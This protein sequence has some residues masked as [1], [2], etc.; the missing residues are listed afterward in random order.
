[1]TASGEQAPA[2]EQVAA[3]GNDVELIGHSYRA[4]IDG[5]AFDALIEAWNRRI[6]SVGH[7]DGALRFDSALLDQLAEVDKLA[8]GKLQIV[9][10]DPVDELLARCVTAA[11]VQNADGRVVAINPKGRESFALET[12]DIDRGAWLAPAQISTLRQLRSQAHERGNADRRVVEC[13]DPAEADADHKMQ[14][15]EARLVT[16]PGY[17]QSLVLV[18]SLEFLWLET[19]SDLVEQS[20]GLTEAE[21]EIAR[22]FYRHRSLQ[23]IAEMRG[24]SVQTI[25]TQFKAVLAKS[26]CRGQVEL[27]RVLTALC[28]QS[29]IDAEPYEGEWVNPYRNEQ[30]IVRPGGKMLGYS[31]AGPK[32]GRPLLW[33]HGP[34]FNYALPRAVLDALDDLR[35]RLIIPCR[36]GYGGSE[37]DKNLSAEED[38]VDALLTLV[39]HLDLRDCPAVGTTSAATML[40]LARDRAPGRF[41]RLGFISNFWKMDEEEVKRLTPIHRAFFRLASSAPQLLN[42]MT[43][44]GLRLVRR[45]G[46]D[47]YIERAHGYNPRNAEALRS[48]ETQAL[49]RTDTRAMMLQNGAGFARD[50]M[51]VLSDPAQALARADRAD[52]WIYGEE[53]SH[54]RARTSVG[55]SALFDR[56]AVEVIRGASDLLLYQRPDAVC[57]LFERLHGDGD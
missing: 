26:G 16:L 32:D 4:L 18:R 39:R 51:L 55:R 33:L 57:C 41:G 7:A 2:A 46:P 6:G 1:M 30:R 21:G 45:N 22:L 34:V 15:A 47:W 37:V 11:M 56:I 54:L 53:D 10:S 31:F 3:S 8:S 42:Y 29:G 12:G 27:I 19:T 14:L 28:I 25:Q 23:R 49:L 40:I 13:V 5:G 20:W 50:R 44:L 48:P 52:I 36:P 43:A 35:V 17:P 24:V 38:N 9:D